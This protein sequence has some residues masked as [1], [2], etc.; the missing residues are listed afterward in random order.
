MRY[1]SSRSAV[2]DWIERLCSSSYKVT[3]YEGIPELVESINLQHT[4]CVD[5]RNLIARRPV[6][7]PAFQ[8]CRGSPHAPQ[9]AQVWQHAHAAESHLCT[10]S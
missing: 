9:E 7:M 8:T 3:E 2:T 1:V 4:G 10:V 5:A 6:L